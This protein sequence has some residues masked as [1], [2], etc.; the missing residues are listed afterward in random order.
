M[1]SFHTHT[2]RHK[3]LWRT[4]WCFWYT[5][6]R[7]SHCHTKWVGL[8]GSHTYQA[9]VG[10]WYC[11][12]Y[13]WNGWDFSKEL[14]LLAIV[15]LKL[16]VGCFPSYILCYW[17]PHTGV[18]HLMI[19]VKRADA[20]NYSRTSRGQERDKEE[21][22]MRRQTGDR[23]NHSRVHMDRVSSENVCCHWVLDQFAAGFRIFLWI[24]FSL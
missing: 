12:W 23:S 18:G 20:N 19:F 2:H 11:Q 15:C 1:G 22:D 14:M 13:Y 16:F 10:W 4:A 5:V 6:H 21:R 7:P 8:T 24:S 3:L 9:K 17:C